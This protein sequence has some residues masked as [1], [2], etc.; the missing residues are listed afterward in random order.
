MSHDHSHTG[1][2]VP[3]PPG[4]PIH[5]RVNLKTGPLWAAGLGLATLI[6]VALGL[7]YAFQLSLTGGVRAVSP[8][9]TEQQL[10]LIRRM[11]PL[12]PNQRAHRVRYEAEQEQLLDHYSWVNQKEQLARIPIQRAMSLIVQKYGKT[13]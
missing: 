3:H 7:M 12:D 13:E 2:D 10:S 5:E 1:A 11:A 8:K 9:A 6:V 4:E